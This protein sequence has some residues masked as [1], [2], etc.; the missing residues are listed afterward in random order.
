M[1]GVLITHHYSRP[2]CR[3]S[4][5]CC[6]HQ[7]LTACMSPTLA[8]NIHP[9]LGALTVFLLRVQHTSRCAIQALPSVVQAEHMALQTCMLLSTLRRQQ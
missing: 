9:L 5:R 3:I 4:I 2:S 1:P 7:H 8:L 6:S